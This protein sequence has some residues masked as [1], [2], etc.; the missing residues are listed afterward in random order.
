MKL[1][2]FKN[3]FNE[4]IYSQYSCFVYVTLRRNSLQIVSIE[5]EIRNHDQPGTVSIIPPL[6]PPTRVLNFPRIVRCDVW[7]A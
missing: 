1:Y 6:D 5:H 2:L 4:L 3:K 7:K